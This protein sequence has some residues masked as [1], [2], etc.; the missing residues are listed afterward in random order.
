MDVNDLNQ[1]RQLDA[2]LA[3][4][5]RTEE[6]TSESRGMHSVSD[7]AKDASCGRQSARSVLEQ[8]Y[9]ALLREANGIHALLQALPG[10]MGLAAEEALW[11][12]VVEPHR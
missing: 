9:E 12:I 1:M 5:K 10:S 11:K 7:C 4:A 3:A 6:A 2:R 8:R